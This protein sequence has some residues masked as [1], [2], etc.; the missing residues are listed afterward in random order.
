MDGEQ[1]A[2]AHT[3]TMEYRCFPG[4]NGPSGYK[5]PTIEDTGKTSSVNTTIEY[6]L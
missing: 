2:R 4:V 5:G 6:Y 1:V 3:L